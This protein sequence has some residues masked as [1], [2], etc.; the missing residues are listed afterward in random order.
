MN[1]TYKLHCAKCGKPVN[2]TFD[3][4]GGSGKCHNCDVEM[5]VGPDTI[6]D[7]FNIAY[8]F[9]KGDFNPVISDATNVIISHQMTCVQC[10]KLIKFNFN[11]SQRTHFNCINCEA[12]VTILSTTQMTNSDF[13]YTEFGLQ[14]GRYKHH[15]VKEVRIGATQ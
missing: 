2:M 11:P 14:F 7:A 10:G 12:I 5:N 13:I 4:P 3:W 15:S 6:R 9:N 8:K 1:V